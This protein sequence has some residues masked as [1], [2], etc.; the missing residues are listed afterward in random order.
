MNKPPFGKTDM[1]AIDQKSIEERLARAYRELNVL[2]DVSHAM[3]TTLELKTILHIILTG[4]TSHS[5]LGF[6][7]A[8][9]Y[10]VHPKTRELVC[11]MAI[12]P[13]SGEHADQIWRYITSS[14]QKLDDLIEANAIAKTGKES[15][16]YKSLK[17][18]RF[19]M[20]G[21]HPTLI[22]QAFQR[23]TPWHLT[24]LELHH[25]QNDP[26]L[27]AFSTNELV[28]MPL[29][30]KDNVNGLII[31]DNLYTGKSISDDDIRIFTMLANQ[32]GLAIENSRLYEVVVQQ[33]HT[34][35]LTSLWNHGFFQETLSKEIEIARTTQRPLTLAMIDLDNFKQLNDTYG[36]QSGD[37]ILKGL[38]QLLKES[39]REMD[40]GCRYGGEEFSLILVQ[41]NCEQGYEIAERLRRRIEHHRWESFVPN[42][43][44]RVTVSV[45]IATFPDHATTKEELITSADKTMYIAK[46]GG[47]N[48]TCIADNG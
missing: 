22:T 47:K 33:S 1:Q 10:L 7:R 25:F 5:G 34:D 41:T 32:A 19:P 3:R 48:K 9:L 26:F 38:A 40:Y 20:S 30:A 18:L 14:N 13:E 42:P 2:Y 8:L 17:G 29:R 28:I 6:N 27:K 21:E 35:S 16:L 36:H 11:E 4:V 46:F 45:G 31:A 43:D 37:I 15:P 24:E 12:A 39:S 23:A 44:I